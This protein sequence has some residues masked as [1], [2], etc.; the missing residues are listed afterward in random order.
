MT[1]N[2]TL[3][4]KSTNDVTNKL[5]NLNKVYETELIPKKNSLI[6]S[7]TA[8]MKNIPAQTTF[9]TCSLHNLRN[10]EE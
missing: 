10:L 6:A 1:V 2:R 7:V 9:I 4:V 3:I 8:K 5:I